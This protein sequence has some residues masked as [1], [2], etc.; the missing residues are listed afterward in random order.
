MNTISTSS[1]ADWR[2]RFRTFFTTRDFILHDGRDLRRFSVGG[3][4]QAALASVLAVTLGFS[5]YGVAQAGMSAVNAAGL[6]DPTSPE[7]RVVALP[8]ELAEVKTAAKAHL[9]QVAQPQGLISVVLTR[10]LTPAEHTAAVAGQECLSE[11]S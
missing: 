3:K 9:R 1:N 11:R 7:E 4:T 6:G 8:A 5:A 10:R 2:A